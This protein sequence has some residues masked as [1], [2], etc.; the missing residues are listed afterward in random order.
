QI[1]NRALGER[2][3]AL[4]PAEAVRAATAV[5][6][7]APPL[8]LLFMGQE[9]AAPEPFLFF[10]ELG[11]DFGAAVSEGRRREFARFPEFAGPRARMRIPDP[12]DERTFARSV[13]DWRRTARTPGREWIDFHRTLLDVRSRDIMPLLSGEPFVFL[14][15]VD[16]REL[17]PYEARDVR[18]LLDQ[19]GRVPVESLFCHTA[20]A[21]LHRPVLSAAYPNDFAVWAGGEMRDQRLAERLAAIDPF[22][23]NSMQHVREALVAV[24]SDRLERIDPYVGSLERMRDRHLT[25]LTGALDEQ[26]K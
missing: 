9:W 23:S 13:L 26:A 18:E 4:A 25:V 2:I 7:L 8:P 17:L 21:L 5:L 19:L 22:A 15:C 16:L 10:S 24:I 11:G 20:A 6:L 1:G 14:G 3:T 12:Q